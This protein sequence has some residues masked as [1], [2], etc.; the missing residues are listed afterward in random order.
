M[1]EGDR[2]IKGQG[3]RGTWCE[4]GRVGEGQGERD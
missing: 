3:E 2:E 1:W 4:R